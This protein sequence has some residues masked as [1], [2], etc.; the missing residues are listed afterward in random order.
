MG[1]AALLRVLLTFA[2][3]A[4]MG[5]GVESASAS[6]ARC[7]A[8][9]TC[10]AYV[11]DSYRWP[12]KAGAAVSIPYYV[13]NAEDQWLSTPQFVGAVKAAADVWMRANPR[14]RLVYKGSTT[15]LP[16][17]VD[18]LNVVGFGPPLLANEEAHAAI[19]ETGGIITEEDMSIALNRTWTWMPCP[20]RNG[21]CSGNVRPI[22]TVPAV[23]EDVLTVRYEEIQGVIEHEFGPIWRFE[24]ARGAAVFYV[25]D[26]G[27][28]AGFSTHE[29]NNRGLGSFGPTGVRISARGRGLGRLLVAASLADLRRLGYH[30]AVIPWTAATEYYRRTCEARIAH[31]FVILR[32]LAV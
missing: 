23:G 19:Q 32:K 21:G 12:A 26:G 16:G 13:N 4:S 9:A 7:P 6:T 31:Q 18:G 11:L 27:E 22:A 29:A 25:E 3:L 1:H 15:A 8:P 30:R 17:I 2:A 20:Q 14:I 24:A 10:R 28:I 5:V